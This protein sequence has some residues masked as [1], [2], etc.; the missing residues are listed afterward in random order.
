MGHFSEYGQYD[1]VGLAELVRQGEVPASEICEEAIRRIEQVNPQLNAVVTPMF[2]IGRKTAGHALPKGPFAGV[3]FLL[4]D[5]LSA[6]AGVP[7]SS[8]AKAYKNFIPDYDSEMVT[9][10]KHAGLVFLGKTNTP[11]FGVMGVTEPEVFGPCRN[12]WQ[13]SVTPGGSSGGAAAA[14]ASGMVPMAGGGDGGG[15]IRIPAA[16]CGLFGFKPS[17]GRNPSGPR[18]GRLWQGAV[19]EH[20]LTRTVRDSAAA[21]D[22]TQGP[23]RGAPYTICPPSR[24]YLQEVGTPAGNLRIGFS[25]TS[26]VGKTVHP[27]C[28][29]AVHDTA[30]L[31]EALGHR[32][33]EG[34]P[35]VDGKALARSYLIMNL[36]EVAADLEEMHQILGRK[37]TAADV[38]PTTC[39]MGVLGRVVSAGEFVAAMRCWDQAARQMGI[40]FEQ[41][42]VYM[43]PTTAYPPAMIGEVQPSPSEKRLMKWV[44]ALELGRILKATGIVHQMAEKMLERTPFTQLANLS[45]LPA[46]SVPL[47]WTPEGLPCGVQ[48]VAGFGR[49][50]L[51]FRLAGQLE[52]ARP[53]RDKKPMVWAQ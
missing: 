45:G 6:F 5:L 50:D 2:D 19:Q 35:N 24:P 43:T 49:E 10:Y 39:T 13:T 16:Y 41:Y 21:L 22:V 26:P 3:P 46:M 23:D 1:A 25:V 8:G 17:R 44:N 30:E 9:R 37:P 34:L 15:S 48:F 33:E 53:W 12:P 38:E 27:E 14:V 32:V 11:E 42:D 18:R 20:V 36:G 31:L 47:H 52:I 7:M 28:A 40:Y 4:K 51:L 29:K